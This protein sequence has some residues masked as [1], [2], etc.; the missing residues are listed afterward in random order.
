MYLLKRHV[1]H[2]HK[3]KCDSANLVETLSFQLT[4]FSIQTLSIVT[5]VVPYSILPRS[6]HANDCFHHVL[7]NRS[8]N[9]RISVG[10]RW[11]V[12]F[13]RTRHECNRSE[14]HLYWPENKTYVVG[15][16]LA[17]R[18]RCDIRRILPKFKCDNSTEAD[19]RRTRGRAILK[20]NIFL[21][22]VERET[23]WSLPS[24][25]CWRRSEMSCWCWKNDLARDGR[26]RGDVLLRQ[27]PDQCETLVYTRLCNHQENVANRM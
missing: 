4:T 16:S 9:A 12:F 25:D 7:I 19:K 1:M 3:G 20:Y 24:P 11:T 18:F 8:F 13:I 21:H 15:R 26:W 14:T 17:R 27:W 23:N 5:D 6:T 2:F 10:L 22:E